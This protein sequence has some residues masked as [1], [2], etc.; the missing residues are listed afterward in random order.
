MAVDEAEGEGR[1]LYERLARRDAADT[2]RVLAKLD[3]NAADRLD[4]DWEFRGQPNASDW[5]IWLLMAGR[6][7]G[8]TRAGAEWVRGIARAHADARIAL[9]RASQIES[10]AVMVEGAS[11]LLAISPR[12]DRPIWRPARR[13]LIWPSAAQATRYGAA[14]PE[15]LRGPEF[16]HAWADEIA[17]WPMGQAAWDNLMMGLRK[18]ML[19]RAVATTTPRP[20]PLVR[21]LMRPAF[22]RAGRGQAPVGERSRPCAALRRWRVGGRGGA[23]GRLLSGRKAR[24]RRA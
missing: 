8:K 6:G 15:G 7:F 13:R 3:A 12:L 24:H 4:K 10:R 17:K 9:V 5:R 11:G 23:I 2:D 20:V 18:G 19:P 1:S 14:D 21:G 22:H 16:S